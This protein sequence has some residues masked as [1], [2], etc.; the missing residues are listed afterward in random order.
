MT[1]SAVAALSDTG[2]S[3]NQGKKPSEENYRQPDY[4]FHGPGNASMNGTLLSRGV[5][6][7]G[8]EFRNQPSLLRPLT[9]S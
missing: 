3:S 2:L 6:V 9:G 7:Q 1:P 8:I 4:A 5:D